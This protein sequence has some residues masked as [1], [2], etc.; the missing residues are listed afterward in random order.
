[1]PA[2]Q[3]NDFLLEIPEKWGDYSVVTMVELPS[4]NGKQGFQHSIVV[5]QDAIGEKMKLKEYVDA[6]I[7]N[8]LNSFQ[9][10]SIDLQED[11]PMNDMEGCRIIFTWQHP[12]TGQIF[13]Q[14]QQYLLKGLRIIVITGTAIKETFDDNRQKFD[15][16]MKSFRFAG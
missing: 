5:T 9:D 11:A 10:C 12:D 4:N 1:M 2:F 7:G 13:K 15:E 16:I 14:M 8:I 3:H 6:Q